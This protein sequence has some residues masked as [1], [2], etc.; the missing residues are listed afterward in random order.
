[1]KKNMGSIDKI[2]RMLI[3]VLLV[4]LYIA[5]VFPETWDIVALVLALILVA[6]SLI[7]LC[8]IY[9]PFGID[10]TICCKKKEN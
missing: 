7:G 5:N 9:L 10:T 1:M 6:T 8:P 3:A 2:I 4:V